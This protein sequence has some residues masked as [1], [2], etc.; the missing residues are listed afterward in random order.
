M[1]PEDAA[2]ATAQPI[3]D[4]GGSFMLDGAT[5][6]RGAELGFGGLDYYVLG[7]GGVLGDTIA[8]VVAA[9]FVFWNPATVAAQW[10]AGRAVMS[11]AE[12][13]GHWADV[14]HTYAE[15]N[16]PDV[17]GLDR[18]GEL[19]AR[20]V[21]AASPACAPVF[22]GWR[23]LEV[24]GSDRP[25]ARALHLV[26]ALRELRGAVHGG[27]VLAAG[28]SPVEAVAFRAPGMAPIFG[29]DPESL[30]DAASVK[31]RWKIAEAG[32]DRAMAG[33][34][35]ALDGVDLDEFTTIIGAVHGAWQAR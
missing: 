23:S 7:R 15:A 22:A 1:T 19:A 14:C 9:G 27:A 11:P 6:A 10:E 12:A 34:L 5:Y 18:L 29:W 8:D 35:S 16:L 4:L 33:A 26:N 28:L 24:P 30:P 21:A 2:R 20:I 13:A 32:T 25:K 31:E 3:G 17:D